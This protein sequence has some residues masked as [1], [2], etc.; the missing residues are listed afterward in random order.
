MTEVNIIYLCS[1]KINYT[2]KHYGKKSKEG[3]S[4]KEGGSQEGS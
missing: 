3:R 2:N 4:Q 1:H